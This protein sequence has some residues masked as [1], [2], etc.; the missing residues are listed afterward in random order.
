MEKLFRNK[1]TLGFFLAWIPLTALVGV[2]LH[3]RGLSWTQAAVL[4][5]AFGIPMS[6]ASASAQ[7]MCKALPLRRSTLT[8]VVPAL[9]GAC[10]VIS[11]GWTAAFYGI[12]GTTECMAADKLAE[13]TL[14]LFMMGDAY[15]AFSLIL[16]Y[17]IIAMDEARSA[18][19]S[20]DEAIVLGR[21]A[22]LRALRAQVNPHFLFNSLNSIAALVSMDAGRARE[23]VLLLSEFFRS[24]LAFGKQKSVTL[25]EELM[26]VDKYLKIEAVRFGDKM[27]V[28][29]DADKACLS[30][31]LPPLLLQPLYENAVKHGV[32]A[33]L[34]T[35]VIK[36]TVECV[37]NGVYFTIQNGFED[38]AP[39]RRGTHLGISTTRER[40]KHFF[41]EGASMSVKKESGS[42]TVTL[43]MPGIGIEES[44]T[45]L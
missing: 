6:F 44:E 30:L 4:S 38:D 36:T 2:L 27:E 9:V 20:A 14:F 25:G 37:K 1:A 8:Q 15:F 3:I 19:K 23:M 29:Q 17:L 26:L 42:F 39:P 33:S 41:G 40:L 43:F 28:I 5:V 13:V 21:E 32:S 34:D 7:Y 10:I 31:K 22:E 18:E 35:V 12:C 11:G 45:A 24:T 16:H